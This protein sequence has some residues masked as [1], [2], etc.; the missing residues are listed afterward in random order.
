MS[1]IKWSTDQKNAIGARG[2]KVLVSAAAGS[3]KTAV[4]TKRITDMLLSEEPVKADR[5]LVV[6]FTKAA[7]KEMRERIEKGLSQELQKAKEDGNIKLEKLIKKQIRLLQRAQISTIDAF[8]QKTVSEYFHIIG[9]SPVFSVLSKS[10]EDLLMK[11]IWSDMSERLYKEQDSDF[12]FL[13]ETMTQNGKEDKIFEYV[14]KIYRFVQNFAYPERFLEKSKSDYLLKDG[15]YN[16]VWGEKIKEKAING[17]LAILPLYNDIPD[18]VEKAELTNI[19]SLPVTEMREAVSDFKGTKKPIDI[20]DSIKEIFSL[21]PKDIDV[22]QRIVRDVIGKEAIALLS[23]AE[24]FLEIMNN[25]KNAL[26]MYSFADI[27]RFTYQLLDNSESARK[28]MQN[29]FDEILIDEY[30]DTNALQD[31]IFEMLTNGKNMFM[32]GDMKQSIYRFRG[33]EPLVFRNK[34]DTYKTDADYKERKI[35]LKENFRS[36]TEVL[37]AVN[38][39]FERCMSLF[40]GEVTYDSSQKL[41][42]G[43]TGYGAKN[44]DYKAEFKILSLRDTE[45]ATNRARAEAKYVADRINKMKKS[46]FL[47]SDSQNGERRRIKNSDILILMSSHKKDGDIFKSVLESEGISAHVEREGFFSKAEIKLVMSVLKIIDNPKR[48]I[49]LVSVLRSPVGGFTDDEIARIRI[50]ERSGNFYDALKSIYSK[51]L[52]IKDNGEADVGVRLFGEKIGNFL[53]KL[54]SLRD[55]ARYLTSSKFTDIMLEETGIKAFAKTLYGR[56]AEANLMLFSDRA[57]E[58]DGLGYRGVFSLLKHMEELEGQSDDLSGASLAAD[59]DAVRI[60]TIHKSKG[61]EEAVVFL[62]GMNKQFYMKDTSDFL[63]LHNNLGICINYRNYLDNTEIVS[64][65]RSVFSKTVKDEL[66]SEEIRKL[67]VALTRA[68]EKI[69]AVGSV[70]EGTKEKSLME[71]WEKATEGEISAYAPFAKSFADWLGPVSK[72]SDFWSYEYIEAEGTEANTSKSVIPKLFDEPTLPEA[73]YAKELLSWQ[74]PY[75]SERIKSK[76]AVSDFKGIHMTN[77][78]EKPKFMDQKGFTGAD[79]GDAVHKIMEMVDLKKGENIDYL[80]TL[81]SALSESGAV[82]KEALKKVTPEK[83]Q[84]FFASDIGKRVA[85]SK[86][87]YR[88]SEFEIALPAKRLYPEIEDEGEMIL[89]QGIIDCWFIEDGEIVLL[90]YKTDKVNDLSEIH[91]KYDIQLALYAEALEKITKKRVKEKVIYLFSEDIVV[92]C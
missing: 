67:Y 7:A 51:Y 6:T 23:L 89:L 70:R 76:A 79:F 8:C 32:V 59:D 19:L 2:A 60:M 10:E 22:A 86:E 57:K 77:M 33:S 58:Y 81:I 31:G 28:E 69:I 15:L 56:E 35:Y 44:D 12:I 20:S 73:E 36:R 41:N 84:K 92:E 62:C 49:P 3:G 48:D 80:E 11:D 38:D 40:V 4:L 21:F 25:K 24:R 43:N 26:S 53:G 64:P 17:I 18:S 46:G 72:K 54:H 68:K 50:Y 87:V 1:D 85:L 45:D 9:I 5:L 55:R 14:Y 63:M 29:R 47:V 65:I 90:D 37:D 16:S 42:L 61:L 13:S 52:L 39:F 75:K 88:E 27:E 83:I 66:L 34:Q 30:Q 91:E 71:K 74:Y 78:P 82:K